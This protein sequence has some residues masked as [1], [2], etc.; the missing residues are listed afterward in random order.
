[1]ARVVVD[2]QPG[3]CVDELDRAVLASAQDVRAS[4]VEDRDMSGSL[5]V[6]P[7]VDQFRRSHSPAVLCRGVALVSCLGRRGRAVGKRQ[8]KGPRAG[9]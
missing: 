4:G 3:L 5:L 9:G 8:G 6:C 1:M 7:R 2:E